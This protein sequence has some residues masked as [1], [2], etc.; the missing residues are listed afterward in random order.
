MKANIAS[1]LR[2]PLSMAATLLTI[3]IVMG[4]FAKLTNY[5][6]IR[7]NL[8]QTRLSIELTAQVLLSILFGVFVG[9]NVFRYRYFRSAKAH[10]KQSSVLGPI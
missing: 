8:G 5:D 2:A 9:L 3:V 1:F 10:L 4:L 6:L 7:G